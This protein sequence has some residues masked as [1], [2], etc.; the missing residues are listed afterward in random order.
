MWFVPLESTTGVPSGARRAI[1]FRVCS[2]VFFEN[3]GRA[4]KKY[5]AAAVSTI[6]APTILSRGERR[7]GFIALDYT[8]TRLIPSLR[9]GARYR[10]P[11]SPTRVLA[12]HRRCVAPACA[13]PRAAAPVCSGWAISP[14]RNHLS[15][16]QGSS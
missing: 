13:G 6:I 14:Y 5:A 10:S 11:R 9:L 3:F 1:L 7:G 16:R 15:Y 8:P 4:Q 12:R 2:I